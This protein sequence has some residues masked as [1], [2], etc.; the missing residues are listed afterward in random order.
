MAHAPLS[1]DSYERHAADVYGWAFRLLGRHEDALDVAQDVWLRWNERRP[2]DLASARGWLRRVTVNRALDVARGRR[3][4]T[5]A[6]ARVGEERPAAPAESDREQ[7]ALRAAVRLG[8]AGLTA[9]QQSVVIAKVYDGLTFA[10]IA[11]EHGIA[12]PTVKTHY[13]RG[14]RALRAS[15]EPTWS[16]RATDGA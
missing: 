6:A 11:Q 2:G 16:E 13:L 3:S 5:V 7:A 4:A 10:R 14:L 8:L 15:L 12:V 1:G 9:T